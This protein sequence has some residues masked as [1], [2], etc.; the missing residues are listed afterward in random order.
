LA[1]R[2]VGSVALRVVLQL[3]AGATA[4]A[5]AS[6]VII[7]IVALAT[8]VVVVGSELGRFP[9]LNTNEGK[10][11]W[12]ETSFMIM[13]PGINTGGGKGASFGTTGT[14]MEGKKMNKTTGKPDEAGSHVR[15]DDVGTTL[16]GIAGFKPEVYGYQGER[17]RFLE[18][19]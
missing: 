2:R 3:V 7:S 13:G 19:A 9:V 16:L 1:H 12:P 17:L 15:I 8:A 5:G 18:Q 14:F 4:A 10:D 6:G 11:H